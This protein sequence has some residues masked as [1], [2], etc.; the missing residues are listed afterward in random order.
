MR[1]LTLALPLAAALALSLTGCNDRLGGE[2]TSTPGRLP[3]EQPEAAS[4]TPEGGAAETPAGPVKVKMTTSKGV[5]ELELDPEKAPKTVANFVAYVKK[6]HYDGTTF[7]RVISDFM[8]QGGG[9]DKDLNEK[10]TD[11][12]I[13]NE[14]Q[15]G[16]RNE[17]GAIAMARTGDPNS[18]TSQFFINTVDN[19]DK[20]DYPRP[21][22][23]GYA[24]F[25]K[26][27]AGMNVVD[28]IR[29]VPTGPKAS[30]GGPPMQDVPIE[31]VTIK[32]VRL[33]E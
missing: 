5:I 27:T 24:V 16:L 17:R 18:A 4:P 28:Q 12:P 25:G 11:S 6:G 3:G 13:E 1:S 10:P 32:S 22:G 9:Y 33:V 31:P 2:A 21:D 14:A 19:M 30:P 23:F 20:L 7:H 8:I 29:A 15:N 26:V